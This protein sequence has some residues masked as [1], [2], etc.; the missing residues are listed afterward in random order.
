MAGVA[1]QLLVETNRAGHKL[2][3]LAAKAVK[4]LNAKT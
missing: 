4:I 2:A 3:K 1:G